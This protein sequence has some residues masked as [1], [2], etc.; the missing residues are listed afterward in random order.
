MLNAKCKIFVGSTFFIVHL[1]FRV[2]FFITLLD[3]SMA[4]GC[5]RSRRHHRTIRSGVNAGRQL[6]R[7]V[8][9]A[10]ESRATGRTTRRWWVSMKSESQRV[11]G[12]L[13]TMTTRPAVP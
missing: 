13:A 2:P 1:S 3:Q 7:G 9:V 5:R 8:S 11:A 6:A 4:T 10:R 12:H